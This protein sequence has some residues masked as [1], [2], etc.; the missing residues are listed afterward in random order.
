MKQNL[1]LK[2]QQIDDLQ[3]RIDLLVL[4]IDANKDEIFN[5]QEKKSNFT[6]SN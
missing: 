1:I 3:K 5:L 6:N 2:N 4:K